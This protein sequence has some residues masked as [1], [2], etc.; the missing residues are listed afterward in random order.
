MLYFPFGVM[1]CAVTSIE[2]IFVLVHQGD[3]S[4][5]FFDKG[6]DTNGRETLR[7]VKPGVVVDSR[8]AVRYICRLLGLGMAV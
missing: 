2:M 1:S 3:G 5:R 8:S 4:L 6:E 7:G